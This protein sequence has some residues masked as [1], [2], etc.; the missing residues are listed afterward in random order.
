MIRV[1][2][3]AVCLIAMLGKSAVATATEELPE[4]GRCVKPAGAANHKYTGPACTVKS[5]GE[6]TGKYEWEPGPGPKA[7]FTSTVEASELES[8]GKTR[9]LC[10]AGSAKGE[11]TGPKTDTGTIT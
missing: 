10:H 2:V 11:I 5:E 1:G 6:N 8:V 4:I 9:L 7:A 3:F